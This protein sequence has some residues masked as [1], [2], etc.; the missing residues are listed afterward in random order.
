M[1]A[2][3]MR[4]HIERALTSLGEGLAP[5]VAARFREVAP[6]IED[7]TDILAQKDSQAGRAFARYNA[8]DISLILR[9]FTE[10]FGSLG[11]IFSSRIGRQA[12]N[13]ASE[14]RDVRNRW[15]HNEDFS[16]AEVYRALDSA[17]M[18][19]VAVGA[20]EAAD[21]IREQK[22]TVLAKMTT[23]SAPEMAAVGP[24]S[25]VAPTTIG[26]PVFPSEDADWSAADVAISI[27]ALPV[28]SYAHA[29]NAIE[30]VDEVTI[31]YRGEELRGAS[32]EI[33]A[34]SR[35]GSLGDPKV[36]I[37]DLDGTT[38]TSLRNAD[39]VLDPVRMLAVEHPSDG[40]IRATLRDADGSV[41]AH[42]DT[43]VTVLA[44]NQWLANPP[45]L[46]LELLA[47]FV[48]PNSPAIAP[49][50]VE[51]S[52]RLQQAT[53]NSRL[54]AYQQ[55][56]RER[57]DAIVEAIYESMRARDIRYAEPPASWG[58]NGQ[59]V[60]TPAEVLDGR[61]GTC[62]D[63]TVTLAAALEEVGINSTL[64]LQDGHIFLGYWRDEASLDGP[65]LMD[66]AEA[67]NYV[68]MGQLEVVE[69][70][71]LTGGTTSRPF[72]DA[73]RHHHLS[74]LA[75]GA[76]SVRGVADVMQARLA[77][78]YPLPS[79]TLSE[80]GEVTIH[81]YAV[82]QAPEALHYAPT[83]AAIAGDPARGIPARVTLWKNAL[84]DLSLR[85]RLINYGENSG[86]PLAVPQPSL[87][88]FEDMINA[89]TAVS[90][91]PNDR[92]PTVDTS[93]GIRFGQDLPETARAS[94][95]AERKQVFVG[96]TDA[97]Y[98]TRLRALAYKARTIVE[99]TG[100]NNLY[101]AFGMLR[102]TFN[103]RELRSPLV[104]VPVVLEATAG[105]KSFR[106]SIDEA[107]ESTPNYCLLEKLRVSY[108]LEIPGLANPAKDDAGID[109]PAAFAAA[110]R[111]VASARLSFTVEDTVDLSILQFGKYRLWK[112]L[113][114]NWQELATNSL[115]G[116]L[117]HTPTNEFVDPFQAPADVDLD[118]LNN[119]VPV[120]ADSS[121]LEAVAEAEAL[122]T[123][124][125]EGPPGTGKS[126]TI[127]NLL[128][129]A[130][131]N[132]KRVLFVAEKR[133]ALDVVKDRLDSVGLGPFSLDL[134]DKGARPNAVRAQIRAA[135][136][137][138][139]R[140]DGASLKSNTEK[141]ASSRRALKRY[142]QRLHEP[143]MAGL[144]M[145][146]AREQLLAMA[147]D[148]ES[149]EVPAALVATGT[150]DQLDELR[151]AL[152]DLP[153]TADLAHP[154]PLH[155]WGF[156]AAS[157][158][159]TPDSAALQAAAREFDTALA[160]LLSRPTDEAIL[161]R[162]T[163]PSLLDRWATLATAPRFPLDAVDAVHARA[164]AGEIPAL[165]ERLN[166]SAAELPWFAAVG[167]EALDGDPHA[168]HTA[169]QGADASG[170]FGRRKRQRAVL[171]GYGAALRVDPRAFPA[172][173]VTALA[174]DIERASDEIRTLR[175]ALLT[176]PVAVVP[177][178]WNPY[179]R[180]GIEPAKSTLSWAVWVGSA[181]SAGQGAA[182]LRN[183][184]ATSSPDNGLAEA[185]TRVAAAWR[186]LAVACG[187][188]DSVEKDD[189]AFV[190][191]ARD[192]DFLSAWRST[193][194]ARNLAS[195]APVTLDRW[196]AFYL[197]LEPLRRLGLTE[198]HN[199]LLAGE[200]PADL[201]SLALEKGI[202]ETSIAERG[203]SQAM[204]GF[205]VRAHNR[206]IDR[207]TSSAAA[208]RSAMPAWIPAEII[209]KRRINP[210][211]EG[212]MM[213][214]LKRQLSRQRGGMSVRALFESYGDL[215]TQIAPC[216]LMSP[217][218]V[219]RFFPAKAKMFDVVV[220]DEASQIRVADAVGAMGRAT[221]VVVVGDSK[222]MPPSSFAEVNSDI[223]ADASSSADVI[224]DE[225]S[226][227]TE[228][229]QARVP[230]K[231]LSWHYRSQD[232]AL[233]SFSN[234]AY[235]D[236]RLSSFPAPWPSTSGGRDADHGISLVR[237][238][239]HFNRSGRGREL[240]TNAAEAEAIVREV[241]R[242]FAASP[243]ETPSLGIIT[244]NAQQ[245]T[246]VESLLRESG[247]AR[248]ALALDERDGLFVK[249]LENVQGDERDCIL[250]S[251]AFSANER[252]VIPLNFGPLSRAGGER[253][254]NVA[255]TRAR[256][257]VVLFAS[258]DPSQL[259][260][261]E[262][263]SL[264]IKHLKGYLEL[265]AVGV[266]SKTDGT[267]RQR[268]ID[269]HRDDI[270]DELRTRGFAVQADLGLS[271]FRVDISVADAADPD[272]PLVAV[273]LDGESWRA[274]RTVADRDG[275][276]VDVLKG[277]MRW[278]GVERVWLPEWLQQREQT[279]SRLGDAVVEARAALQRSTV[280]PQPTS[281]QPQS[282]G[283]QQP[284]PAP[285]PAAQP[286]DPRI[287]LRSA[288][289]PSV[290]SAE[291]SHSHL[292]QYTPWQP[293]AH[294][295]VDILDGLPGS[296]A[297]QEVR[298][299][300]LEI[301]Q[302][303]GPVHKLRLARLA[304]ESFGLSRVAAARADAILRC[305][306][307]EY[308][309]R[310]DKSCAWPT[311]MDPSE[312]REVRRS[313]PGDGRN[314]EHV[315]LEEI[316]NAMAVV[317]ELGGGMQQDE[318]KRQALALFGGKRMTEGVAALLD[319][320]LECGLTTGRIERDERGLYRAVRLP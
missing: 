78:I 168:V 126:Q 201:A 20:H 281:V 64:W 230:R 15:A 39:L 164:L 257:Q 263:A 43:P 189:S 194:T 9:A 135:M 146:T 159:K 132:G 148:I 266:E 116:H 54:D 199:A 130:L 213:G 268:L 317:A 177:A 14:L 235:Y 304:A 110:R 285:V 57:V 85:N 186:A 310:S 73:R 178:D 274:R 94:M 68:G 288:L 115:V 308:S 80:S 21:T 267:Q 123:F 176:L 38:P 214:E 7:W 196:I 174:A 202:A 97:T 32:V 180:E 155:P 203:D 264:G 117:V 122:R 144:S 216:V 223:D 153:E 238:D 166:G 256:R 252:G 188:G 320:G 131:A 47:S 261:E 232:E 82:A 154:S 93:R 157:A 158:A 74:T 62:L 171:A 114:E 260:A 50:L 128:A 75:A 34:I 101:L 87:A 19:L 269:R 278:P 284:A 277:L 236:S 3:E 234:H 298:A 103:D 250:F 89:G 276:P 150:E 100:A 31:D 220:F 294:G 307:P 33:E 98:T 124:V 72:A 86:Y 71:S 6:A 65:A 106:I 96:V 170:F 262:T 227:L 84:L 185:L 206:T 51:A 8:R 190:A 120:P 225:E 192:N 175:S 296:W 138:G 187:L 60:R 318:L 172:R 207:F 241:E 49:L 66:A 143:N 181:L 219:A 30:I 137:A 246:L 121:Q 134:H 221:S 142:A 226:I 152:R 248:I 195:A 283:E 183:Y 139:A 247:D 229:V 29:R 1:S 108:G 306:P 224:L 314:L 272:Q 204:A 295:T 125:L 271:D 289:A 42:S 160:D 41:I 61:L 233:I 83:E 45:Q 228:C 109:L 91:V 222:Q 2:S 300:L 52:D 265:A 217:E 141:A 81:E 282:A 136:D 251:V 253:R 95:L 59:K 118:A 293:R 119:A 200:G 102:W 243:A 22:R 184:Y 208:I 182:E 275:L 242:R 53:G 129:H 70:T 313:L 258:F 13:W 147:D 12:Q 259:R 291:L 40:V 301:V 58:L 5:V 218:S 286:D 63:T 37:V 140:P 18:L 10:S 104:L 35:L 305:L 173:D 210:S 69:T 105:G 209:G 280:E 273:L 240:R 215:I 297:T 149:L 145:Y 165:Q 92:I 254:L 245:R 302:K 151:R 88:A 77:Q 56:S 90:L 167:P 44:A 279:L 239:G 156:V 311:G 319:A 26:G 193:A 46:S 303:E 48:Q 163:S 27:S 197:Q 99:E 169:A 244:F 127:T 309:R 312:W 4:D 205:D 299:V 292:R 11:Y 249:N 290:A 67:A 270:A 211:Y 287:A 191:W 112:D 79:R 231:W 179:L 23:E 237:V 76:S 25:E 17:E 113:D 255:I 316:A 111:A 198:A 133:A 24:A 161:A 16:V 315:P 55:G 162:V 107:G 28:V 36:V 212:G